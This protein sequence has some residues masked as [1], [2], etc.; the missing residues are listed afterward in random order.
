ME[1]KRPWSVAVARSI[2]PGDVDV[3]EVAVGEFDALT[4]QVGTQECSSQR[5]AERC[6]YV[7]IGEQP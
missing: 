3:D 6:L 5:G 2:R 7:T 4:L 1:H